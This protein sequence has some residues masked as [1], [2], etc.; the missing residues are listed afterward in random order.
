M[1]KERMFR[2]RFAHHKDQSTPHGGHKQSN[3]DVSQAFERE[4]LADLCNQSTLL[5]G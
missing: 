2:E 5:I 3:D 1:E 4:A